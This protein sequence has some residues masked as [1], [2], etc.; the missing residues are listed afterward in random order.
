MLKK[1]KGLLKIKNFVRSNKFLIFF[2]ISPI[3][4][5]TFADYK[6]SYNI[7]EYFDN[8]STSFNFDIYTRES[9]LTFKS[10]N[11]RYIFKENVDT[12]YLVDEDKKSVTYL[13]F[14]FFDFF[15][16]YVDKSVVKNRKIS[17]ITDTTV[18]GIPVKFFTI[19]FDSSSGIKLFVTKE[20]F[21]L[22]KVIKRYN[23]ILKSY[24]NVDFDL[25]F[26]SIF[27]GVPVLF[28]LYEGKD[29]TFYMRLLNYKKGDFEREFVVPSGYKI[30]R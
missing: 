20:K 30:N 5:L 2:I 22:S 28:K 24:L 9:F 1:E 3:F 18:S 13:S 21:D 8:D 16:S 11:L 19:D 29:E 25:I 10:E 4:L 14:S 12:F 17:F 23:R 27:G 26:D 15:S 6:F 7:K